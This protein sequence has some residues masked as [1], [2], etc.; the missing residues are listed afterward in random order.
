MIEKESQFPHTVLQSF[1][2]NTRVLLFHFEKI[3]IAETEVRRSS[4]WENFVTDIFGETRQ[5]LLYFN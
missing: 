5:F 3:L 2:I 1:M 4:N